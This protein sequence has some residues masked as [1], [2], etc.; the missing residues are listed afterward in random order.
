MRAGYIAARRVVRERLPWIKADWFIDGSP[1][2]WINHALRGRA[3]HSD[4]PCY[5]FNWLFPRN[6]CYKIP[7]TEMIRMDVK[8]R[9]G[10]FIFFQSSSRSN[11]ITI[12]VFIW[13]DVVVELIMDLLNFILY[14]FFFFFVKK[15]SV[16]QNDRWW[17]NNLQLSN[18]YDIICPW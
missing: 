4:F 18:P 15:N 9:L 17:I 12:F 16:H 6:F 2:F 11:K 14:H 8:G 5:P 3:L 10:F 7:C 1:L 13:K